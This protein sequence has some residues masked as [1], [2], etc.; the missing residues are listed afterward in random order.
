L[1]L[2]LCASTV[3]ATTYSE[4][5]NSKAKVSPVQKVIQ[6]LEDMLT[7][8]KQEKQ[9]EEVRFAAFKQFCAGSAAEKTRSIEEADSAIGKIT[10]EIEDLSLEVDQLGADIQKADS[11]VEQLSKK[12]GALATEIN[13]FDNEMEANKEEREAEHADFEKKDGDYATSIDSLDRAITEVKGAG[14]GA[15]AALLQVANLKMVPGSAKRKIYSFLQ[16]DPEAMLQRDAQGQP[17]G[18]AKAYEGQTDGIVDMFKKLDEKFEDEREGGQKD[19][20][21]KK[22]SYDML[23]QE[24]T[25][26][27]DKAKDEKESKTALKAKR[28]QDLASAKG[29]LAETQAQK[30]EDEKYLKELNAEC[31][32]KS[33]DFENRQEMRAGEIGAVSKAVEILSGGAVAGASSKHLELA[34]ADDV[35]GSSFVQLRSS[36][37]SPI[38]NRVAV[39]LQDKATA[40][41]SRILSM[42]AAHVAD[43]PF[44]KVKKMIKDMITRLMEEANEEAEHKGWCDTEL[45]TN[46][47][48]RN[49]KTAQVD[50]LHSTIEELQ[51]KL[52]KIA[53]ELQD[54]SAEITEL[55]QAVAEATAQRT[56]EKEANAVTVKEAGEA[57][58]AVAQAIEV[59]KEFYAG[60]AEAT[61]LAQTDQPAIFDAPYT[62]MQ[63]ESGG[64]VGMLEVIQSDFGRLEAETSASEQEASKAHKKFLNESAVNKARLEKD[65]EHLNRRKTDRE[66]D[67]N[68]ATGDLTG[69]QEELDAALAYYEKLKPSC[70]DAGVTYEDRVGR[71]KE[72]IE[73]LQEALRILNGE[74]IA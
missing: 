65:V 37:R 41:G 50:T 51:A 6:M 34:Q 12:I 71:R 54:T 10:G 55:S 56:K 7:K 16:Q 27:L 73:S 58:T 20:M 30:A 23:M 5:L 46:T 64:V 21:A 47:V 31:E 66:G 1:L 22:H 74:D 69:A 25:N 29:E 52:Q 4:T 59:L 49:A 32:Q 8:S 28:E 15:S 14:A 68:E 9:D 63:G 70:V 18:E 61:S 57:Q 3:S 45:K 35:D 48:T 67:L 38:Q 2:L 72:E 11:D 44:T 62:G 17:T 53:Q 13:N 43:D 24:L 39:F 40:N 36:G 26:L 33:A 42:L 60:A 19:E